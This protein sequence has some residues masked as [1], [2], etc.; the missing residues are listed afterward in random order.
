VVDAGA[1]GVVIL[2]DALRAALLGV[3][4]SEPVGPPRSVQVGV[5]GGSTGQPELGFEVQALLE[6]DE[7]VLASVR[8][9]LGGIGESLVIVGGGGQFKV[10]VHT[11]KPEAAIALLEAAG[12]VNDAS[13]VRL[14]DRTEQC[15]GGAARSVRVAQQ[16]SALVVQAEGD[17]L[18]AA[19]RS[20][21]ADVVDESRPSVETFQVALE[22]APAEGVV[23]MPTDP[24]AI[25]PAGR[26]AGSASKEARVVA[27]GSVPAGLAAATAFD[28]LE[29]LGTNVSSMNEAA[30]S[31][32]DGA[33]VAGGR[34]GAPVEAWLG[35][36]HGQVV[37][38]GRS[39]E[40]AATDLTVRLAAD[41]GAEIVT[42]VWGAGGTSE[43][44]DDVA[45]AIRR[46]LPEAEVQVLDGGQRGSRYLIGVE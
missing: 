14:E 7:S 15:L 21:G 33:V 27:A 10:H 5:V 4:L 43:L 29:D 39:A 40:E 36:V 26:A 42:I 22:G 16:A 38:S 8:R 37:C 31:V 35:L 25:E 46:R 6:T 9:G 11:S 30:G 20:L 17:G 1:K 3:P 24:A 32:R 18:G 41:E 2:L 45:A 44:S 13:T 19:F 12:R 34:I 28:P 23:L